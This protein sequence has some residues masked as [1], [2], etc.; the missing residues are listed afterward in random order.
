MSLKLHE[1][2]LIFFEPENCGGPLKPSGVSAAES[3]FSK[4]FGATC[5]GDSY[6]LFVLKLAVV[7][8]WRLGRVEEITCFCLRGKILE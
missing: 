5:P 4:T 3:F 6:Y 7:V 2:R 1:E 8:E